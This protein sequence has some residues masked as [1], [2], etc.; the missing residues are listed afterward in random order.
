[1]VHYYRP[2]KRRADPRN[3]IE[4]Q[5]EFNMISLKQED[6]RRTS[7]WLKSTTHCVHTQCNSHSNPLHGNA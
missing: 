1:M 6:K 7:S 2:A 4:I 5:V 3:K